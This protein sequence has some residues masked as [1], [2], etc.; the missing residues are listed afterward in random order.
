MEN[1]L[2]S[3]VKKE[4]T[5]RCETCVWLKEENVPCECGKGRGAV[6]YRRVAC[7]DYR[8]KR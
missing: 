4:E 3:E 6:F 5:K 8:Q 7:D 2:N 1:N